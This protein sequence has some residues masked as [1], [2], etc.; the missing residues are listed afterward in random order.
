MCSLSQRNL[1]YGCFCVFDVDNKQM[2][3]NVKRTPTAIVFAHET[4]CLL[5]FSLKFMLPIVTHRWM[6]TVGIPKDLAIEHAC[7]PPAPPKHASTWRA[8]SWPLAS[9]SALIGRHIVSLATVMKPIATCSTLK[10]SLLAPSFWDDKNSFTW[11]YRKSGN[12]SKISV[13][14]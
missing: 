2:Y 9:V 6:K 13:I 8:V 3:Q 1:T 12:V 10:G 4:N 5:A 11:F 14:Y 7:C